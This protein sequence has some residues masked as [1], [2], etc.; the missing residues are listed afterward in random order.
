VGGLE[1]YAVDGG[2]RT[3]AVNN[4]LNRVE[5]RTQGIACQIASNCAPSFASNNDLSIG[6]EAGPRIG[7]QKGPRYLSAHQSIEGP[8]R[9]AEPLRSAA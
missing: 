8:A 1:L 4:L 3:A 6:E 9:V 2:A 5:R 7:V